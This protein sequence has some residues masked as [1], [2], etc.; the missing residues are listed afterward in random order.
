MEKIVLADGTELEVQSGASLGATKIIATDFAGLGTIAEALTKEG[1]LATVQYKNGDRVTGDYLDMKLESPLFT[2]VD[3]YTDDK[4]VI[5]TI[6]I[7]E[8]TE[9]E[10]RLD[11]IEAKQAELDQSQQ[12]QDGAILDLAGMVGGEA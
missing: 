9:V 2:E 4:K 8:K 5:A 7:R 6:R 1:N 10:K 11:A 3:Y 12:I